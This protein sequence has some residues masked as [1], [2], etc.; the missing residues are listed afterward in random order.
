[1]TK[2][3]KEFFIFTREGV[4]LFHLD[5]QDTNN[6]IT[7]NNNNITNTTNTTNN[8]T[9]LTNNNPTNIEDTNNTLNT[10]NNQQIIVQNKALSMVTDKKLENKYKL[11]F[12]FLFSMKS[13]IKNLSPHKADDFFKSYTTTTY[14]IHYV[15]YINGLRFV[16][17]SAP[18]KPDLR[19]QIDDIYKSFYVNYISKNFFV[20]KNAV[21]KNDIFAELV[22]N[23][24]NSTNMSLNKSK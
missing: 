6:I 23:Y 13:F 9:N 19:N 2:I 7:I 1:M 16:I 15:E 14:K 5:L 4:C 18:I 22:L 24:L 20:E 10:F 21:I 11:I 12:G 3:I 17:F 8:L